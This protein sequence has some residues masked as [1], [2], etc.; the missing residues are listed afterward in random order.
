MHFQSALTRRFTIGSLVR[1]HKV[2]FSPCLTDTNPPRIQFTGDLPSSSRKSLTL[3]WKSDETSEFE[4][5]LDV[6]SNFKRCGGG[7]QGQWTNNAL[8]EG[9]H[10]F[11]VRAKDELNNEGKP[12]AHSWMVGKFA[13]AFPTKGLISRYIFYIKVCS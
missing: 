1:S 13:V 10:T 5:A 11:Y 4:C 3:N 8:P 7:T 12:I 6:M 9:R 2:C